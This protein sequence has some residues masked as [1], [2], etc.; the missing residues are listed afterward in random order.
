MAAHASDLM[1]RA[2]KASAERAVLLYAGTC[3]R[4]RAVARTII[5]LSCGQIEGLSLNVDEW[6]D[7]YDRELPESRGHPVLFRR[8]VATWGPRV[9]PLALYVA[10]GGAMTALSRAL[11]RRR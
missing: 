7:F 5:L 1:P 10:V 9:F 8:G 6:R 2:R 11:G 4:C 3:R